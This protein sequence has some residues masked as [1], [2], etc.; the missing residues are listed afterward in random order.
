MFRFPLKYHR[1]SA[2]LLSGIPQF[3][4][5]AVERLAQREQELGVAFPESV[6]EWYSIECA[7]DLLRQLFNCYSDLGVVHLFHP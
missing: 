5:N 4:A 6:R 7:V 1:D 2:S 3:S